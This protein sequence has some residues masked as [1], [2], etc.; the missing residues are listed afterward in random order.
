ML[1]GLE[2]LKALSHMLPPMDFAPHEI[3]GK[4]AVEVEN[5]KNERTREMMNNYVR[6]YLVTIRSVLT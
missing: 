5:M 2:L 4:T 1:D 6:E 3:R